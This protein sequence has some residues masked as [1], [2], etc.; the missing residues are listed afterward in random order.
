MSE[1]MLVD[2]P[3]KCDRTGKVTKVPMTLIDA[4]N[5]QAAV[6]RKEESGKEVKAYLSDLHP[7]SCPDLVVL[8]KGSS[9]VLSV[10]MDSPAVARSLNALTQDSKFPAPPAKKR[11]KGGKRES[12]GELDG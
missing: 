10:V 4:A 1:D 5:F 7:D 6:Q 9:V 8:Y 3:V 11:T 2:V 12:S